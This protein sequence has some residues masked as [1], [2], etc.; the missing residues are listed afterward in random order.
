MNANRKQ[1]NT[2]TCRLE[3]IKRQAAAKV[4]D[5]SRSADVLIVLRLPERS[6]PHVAIK[7]RTKTA[8]ATRAMKPKRTGSS[9]AGSLTPSRPRKQIELAIAPNTM[10][11]VSR[12][13]IKPTARGRS[14]SLVV[15]ITKAR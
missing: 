10:P 14:C 6:M 3:V 7:V 9:T 12:H 1:K 15:S 8:A 5:S 11:T 4:I 2:N 13:Q